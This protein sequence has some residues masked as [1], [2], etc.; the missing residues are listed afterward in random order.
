MLTFR[1]FVVVKIGQIAYNVA[2]RAQ[3][4]VAARGIARIE[5]EREPTFNEVAED[6]VADVEGWLNGQ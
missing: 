3:D 4:W 5:I 2:V 6:M 1:E